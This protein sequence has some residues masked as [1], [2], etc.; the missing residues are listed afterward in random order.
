MNPNYTTNMK[1]YNPPPPHL[2]EEL[3]N[4]LTEFICKDD[5]M[6]VLI[7]TA[8]A[9]YQFETIHPFASGNGRVGRI[10]PLMILMQAGILSRPMLLL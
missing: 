8:L 6:D 3:L 4:D 7:K 1:E 9:Y 2:V 10:L 5:T